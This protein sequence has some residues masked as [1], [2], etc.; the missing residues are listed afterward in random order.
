MKLFGICLFVLC[1]EEL[2]NHGFELFDLA[3]LILELFIQFPAVYNF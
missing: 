3:T 2:L 1:G